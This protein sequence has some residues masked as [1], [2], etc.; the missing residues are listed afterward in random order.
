[1]RSCVVR[2]YWSR[3][4]VSIASGSNK[5]YWVTCVGGG[6]ANVL[7]AVYCQCGGVDVHGSP[8]SNGEIDI[9]RSININV[10]SC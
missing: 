9:C 5:R 4:D 10:G 8:L 1:M 3:E 7:F 2:R 6:Y